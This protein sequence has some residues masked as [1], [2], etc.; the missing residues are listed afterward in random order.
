M[1]KVLTLLSVAAPLALIL[2]LWV[3]AQ[4][5]RRFGEVTHRP[6]LYRWFYVAQVLLISP[7]MV[8]LLAIGLSHRE[9]QELG[10]NTLRALCH[11]LPLAL[12]ITLSVIVAWRYW[13]WLIYAR[14][15]NDPVV[16]QRSK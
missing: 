14:E 11:D 1:S 16:P 7:V 5:S 8:R 2:S 9:N 10:G 6:P 13:G 3:M 12:S 15:E 4:I